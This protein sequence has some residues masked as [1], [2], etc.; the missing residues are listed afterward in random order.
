M[1]PMMANYGTVEVGFFVKQSGMA[2]K[3]A[4]V[5]LKNSSNI[6]NLSIL[7]YSISILM[8]VYSVEI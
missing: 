2:I 1:R 4:V 3:N 7:K 5:F 8:Y 6:E